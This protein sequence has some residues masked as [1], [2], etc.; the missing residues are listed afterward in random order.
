MQIVERKKDLHGARLQ[1]ILG[2]SMIRVAIEKIPKT[3]PHGL[4]DEAVMVSSGTRNGKYIQGF[5]HMGIARMRRIAL[6]QMLV[7]VKVL[8]VGFSPC[9]HL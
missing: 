7:N 8:P 6:V 5:S 3:L 4:L 1:E 2:E 9:V